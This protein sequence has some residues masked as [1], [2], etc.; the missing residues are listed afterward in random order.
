MPLNFRIACWI[1]GVV[2]FR[3][4]ASLATVM[5]D[6]TRVVCKLMNEFEITRSSL[7]CASL[8]CST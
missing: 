2:T 8:H 1:V 4:I 5:Q 7:D 3:F 6:T